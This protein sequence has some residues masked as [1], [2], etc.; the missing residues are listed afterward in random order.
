MQFNK[1]GFAYTI[2]RATG[3]VLVA[4][5]FVEANWATRIDLATRRPVL[6]STKLTG[7]A[8]T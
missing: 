6:D 7:A 3:E 1:N 5:A 8:G 2:D 4:E